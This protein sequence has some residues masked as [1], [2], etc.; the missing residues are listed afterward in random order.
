MDVY[1]SKKVL[2]DGGLRPAR[3]YVQ[4]GKIMKVLEGYELPH[5]EIEKED[6]LVDNDFGTLVVMPGLVDS[7]VH[8][9]DPGRMGWEGCGVVTRGSGR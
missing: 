9:N 6:V 8:I 1:R 7:V 5:E 2:L 3:I 4:K